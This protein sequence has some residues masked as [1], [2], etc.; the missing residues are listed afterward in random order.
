MN[1]MRFKK[2]RKMIMFRV[3]DSKC[4]I[5]FFQSR[6]FFEKTFA[7]TTRNFFFIKIWRFIKR[8]FITSKNRFSNNFIL[9]FLIFFDQSV[10]LGDGQRIY[11]NDNVFECRKWFEKFKRQQFHVDFR[12]RLVRKIYLIR[13]HVIRVYKML[14]VKCEWLIWNLWNVECWKI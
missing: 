2:C 4:S 6:D 3:F 11:S 8:I 1:G 7:H 12:I 14:H 13:I 5:T 10:F 9:F